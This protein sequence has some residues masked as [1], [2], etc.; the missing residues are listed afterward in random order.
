[1]GGAKRRALHGAED[2]SKL[3]C[4]MAGGL[5]LERGRCRETP[6]DGEIHVSDDM[7]TCGEHANDARAALTKTMD[8]SRA[9]DSDGGQLGRE[10][11]LASAP[12]GEVDGRESGVAH[13]PVPCID[14]S[15]R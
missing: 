6:D 15:A 2:R 7:M 3:C 5:P 13:A 8:T 9:E 11:P 10:R 12:W 1:M 14:T 4:V